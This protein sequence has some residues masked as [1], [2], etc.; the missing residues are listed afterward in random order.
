MYTI[1]KPV[2]VFFI[3]ALLCGCKASDKIVRYEYAVISR[4]TIES[5]V[6]STGTLDA[7]A[8]VTVQSPVTGVIE[9]LYADYNAPVR[10]GQILAEVNTAPNPAQKQIVAVYSP[11]DGIVLDRTVNV[12]GAVLARGSPAATTLFTLASGLAEM[13]ITASIGELDIASI[14]EGQEVHVTLQSLPGRRYTS[15]VESVRLMPAVTDN[16]VSYA[17]VTRLNNTDGSLRPG[18]TCALQ[19][20][21]QKEENAFVVPNATLRFTPA[22]AASAQTVSTAS[23]GTGGTSVGGSSVSNVTNA[24]TGGRAGGGTNPFGHPTGPSN[25]SGDANQAGTDVAPAGPKPERTL[26]YTDEV[27][28]LASLPVY[29]GTSDGLRTAV[30]PVEEGRDIEGMRIILR[31]AE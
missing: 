26:W 25:L 6:S 20:V 27:G 10:K 21:Q 28:K 5:T 12:G 11:I 22:D 14:K 8:R 29:V 17:V 13:K 19:F 4:G 9:A 16:V 18:M 30:S 24:I 15:K 7:E 31:E 3:F 2:L 23:G 1:Y